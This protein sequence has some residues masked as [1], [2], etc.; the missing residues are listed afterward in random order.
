MGLDPGLRRVGAG[1]S[2]PHNLTS[3]D[4]RPSPDASGDGAGPRRGGRNLM[5]S[6]PAPTLGVGPRGLCGFSALSGRKDRTG[7]ELYAQA[8]C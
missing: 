4:A 5:A 2:D 6:K 1:R 8:K 3:E 7:Y